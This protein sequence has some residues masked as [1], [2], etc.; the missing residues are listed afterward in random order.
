[1]ATPEPGELVRIAAGGPPLDG[2]VFDVPS[3]TKVIVAVV[4]RTKGP[5]FRT[6]DPSTVTARE[7]P[8]SQDAPLRALIRRT[9]LPNRSSGRGGESGGTGGAAGFKR[10]AAH[11]ATGR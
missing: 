6:V 4:D 7:A 9:P 5:V 11:R 1:M 8:G 3:H 2:I 10:G